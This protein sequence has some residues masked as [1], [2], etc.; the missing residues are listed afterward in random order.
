MLKQLHLASLLLMVPS[1]LFGQSGRT[2]SLPAPNMNNVLY[3]DGLKYSTIQAAVNALPKIGGKP[4]GIVW[5]TS[6][7][8]IASGSEVTIGPHTQ[9]HFAAN[10]TVTYTGVGSAF[11]C[12]DAPTTY[13]GNGGIYDLQMNVTAPGGIGINIEEC[14]WFHLEHISVDAVPRSTAILYQNTQKWTEQNVW[15]D[16]RVSG[17]GKQ[18]DFQ[19]NCARHSGCNSFGYMQI[20]KVSVQPLAGNDGFLMENDSSLNHSDISISCHA[21]NAANCIHLG[22][23]SQISATRLYARGELA[24][25]AKFATG[26]LSDAGTVYQPIGEQEEWDGPMTDALHGTVNRYVY[27]NPDVT[28]LI[29]SATGLAAQARGNTFSGTFDVHNI[30]G[31]RT[32]TAPDLSGTNQ[33]VFASGHAAMPTK[34]LKAN[35]CSDAVTVDVPGVTPAMQIRWNLHS[36]PVGVNGYG[37]S[38]VIIHAWPAPGK[39]NFIQCAIAAVSP[40][41]MSLDWEAT[42]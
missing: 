20:Y 14:T 30:T 22:N 8:T 3:V 41:T 35:A 23:S 13:A 36:T 5:V 21:G 11:L 39:V 24:E 12:N 15:Y 16:V 37:N 40:G 4:V 31:F 26:L 28:A 25:G 34:T 9:L 17:G 32:W 18:I 19:D 1:A 38:P 6:P 7:M 42:N 29:A 27:N 2:E 33:I 10:A